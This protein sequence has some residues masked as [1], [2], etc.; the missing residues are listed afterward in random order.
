MSTIETQSLTEIRRDL[1]SYPEAGWKEFRTTAL[2]AEELD[3]LGYELHLGA[4]ALDTSSQLGVPD[5]DELS[6]ALSRAKDEGAPEPYVDATD[7]VTGLVA[8]TTFGD[9]L[10]GV[11]K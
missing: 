9:N 6:R 4:D 10:R 2:V 5:D 7:G 3:R 8:E 11:V 1:H